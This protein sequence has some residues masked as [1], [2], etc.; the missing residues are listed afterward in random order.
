MDSGDIL[1]QETVPLE[2]RETTQ[3]L[4]LIMAQKAA[5]LLPDALK[6]IAA[7]TL[8][9]KAQDGGTASFCSLISKDDGRID[10]TK[11]ALEIEAQIRAYDPWPLSWTMQEGQLLFILKAEAAPCGEGA[12]LACEGSPLPSNAGVVLGI[13]KQKGILIQTGDGVLALK[14]LQYKARKALEWRAFLNGARGFI[15]S[16]LN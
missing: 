4:S 11:S 13:D 7:G 12:A 14:E 6:G 16:R 15:G 9:G 3:S 2:G 1:V 8:K 10:W 5:L